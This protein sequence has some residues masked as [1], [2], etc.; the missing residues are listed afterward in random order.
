MFFS[1]LTLARALQGGGGQESRARYTAESL[2]E[3]F[4]DGMGLAG[5][6]EGLE[7]TLALCQ[8]P[9]AGTSETDPVDV[10]EAIVALQRRAG[11]V[12]NDLRFLM[13]AADPDFVYYIETRGRG[14]F[15]RASPID[16]SRIV[17]DVLLERMRAI[18]LTSATL[19]VDGSFEYLKGR[20]GIRQAESCSY[21]SRLAAQAATCRGACRR[22]RRQH[23]PRPRP[24]RSP[25]S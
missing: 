22:R 3:H 25:R 4:E 17:R 18:V 11:E 23:L 5:A 13:R 19:A 12:R 15:L 10:N 14:M 6:L 20:L 8:S 9:S 24:A 7:A 2:E 1:G 21:W 16:V